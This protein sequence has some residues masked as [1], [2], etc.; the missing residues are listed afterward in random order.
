M[1]K[2]KMRKSNRNFRKKVK[3]TTTSWADYYR[4]FKT[5]W[6]VQA[7]VFF[8][9]STLHGVRYIAENGRPF[10]EKFMW[11]TCVVVSLVT[12][13]III[14][15]LWEK[16]QTNPTITGLDTDFHNWEVP[17]PAITICQRQ[18]GNDTRIEEFVESYS[19]DPSTKSQFKNFMQILT[20]LSYDNI[21]EL[22]KFPNLNFTFPDKSL[23]NIIFSL[24]NTC[25]DVFDTCDW[26]SKPYNCCEGFFPTFTESGFCYSFNSRHYEKKYPWSEEFP[27]F[28]MHYIKETDL[29]WSLAF[30]VKEMTSE[31]PIYILNSDEMA[32]LDMNPQHI[33]NFLMN[34]ISF[35][36]KQTYTTEDT[37][38]LSIRQR[39]CVFPDEKKLIIDHTY[40]YTAC[41]R[42]CR[43]DN[44]M[45]FCQC[46][47]YFYHIEASSIYKYCEISELTCIADNLGKIIAVDKC[48][49]QL[50]CFN[51]VYEVEKLNYN[52]GEE[53]K[54][55]EAE[56]MSWPMIR[57]KREVLFGW[58]DLLVSFGGIAGLFL[59]FSLLSG[60]EIIYYFTI[61][62][63]FMIIKERSTLEK[64]HL[65]HKSKPPPKY[66]LSLTPYFISDPLP[67]HG[68][69]ELSKK[70]TR[71]NKGIHGAKI[72]PLQ[73][74]WKPSDTIMPPFGIEYLD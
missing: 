32:G 45:K 18:P 36:V 3:S 2:L 16:F 59:G 7:K 60:V 20:K 48:E 72:I 65:E 52:E 25:E 49:C 6:R 53:T 66:D 67:G 61:R 47:P 54:T 30:T 26:K 27:P 41:A 14:L 57:Y 46:I 24:M 13:T 70:N 35:S 10:F 9:N 8:E 23:K 68:I 56:F 31:M 51:T 55:M 38:Q 64:I 33:W 62:A 50:G 1:N 58:V 69:N 5:S 74:N 42:Q 63:Y 17:F 12:S 40:T 39:H 22:G 29:K 43:M 71:K 11:F 28:H 34:T 4:I 19:K 37:R 21:K 15:S 44:A 73:G